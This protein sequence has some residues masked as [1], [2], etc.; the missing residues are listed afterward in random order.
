VRVYVGIK[1]FGFGF[2]DHRSQGI[3]PLES[4]GFGYWM[5]TATQI[6]LACLVTV[7]TALRHPRKCS[8]EEQVG[9]CSFLAVLG[10]EYLRSLITTLVFQ[11]PCLIEGQGGNA[12]DEGDVTRS[13]ALTLFPGMALGAGL[14]G[15]MLGIGGGMIMNPLL[16][17]IG[18]HPQ[19]PHFTPTFHFTLQ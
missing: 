13:R 2:V 11:N 12:Q 8:S 4:C 5:L 6:P 16:I 7:W 10:F 15:G 14:L 3:L 17:E 1:A 18:M 9:I 19:V